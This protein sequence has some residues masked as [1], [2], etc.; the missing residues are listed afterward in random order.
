MGSKERKGGTKHLSMEG[1]EAADLIF[2]RKNHRSVT[3]SSLNVEGISHETAKTD[4]VLYMRRS[5]DARTMQK[6]NNNSELVSKLLAT[7]LT[8]KR[9]NYGKK[10]LLV[11]CG[12]PARG[13]S[14]IS[15]KLHRYLSWMGYSCKVFNVGNLRR[16]KKNENQEHDSEFFDPKNQ[17]NCDLRNRLAMDAL[18]EALFWLMYN[19]G[20]LAIH[21]ATNSNKAR[22]ASILHRCSKE[23]DLEVIFVESICTDA[24]VLESNIRLK[25]KSPDYRDKDPEKALADFRK[26]L[27]NYETSYETIEDE[28]SDN[29]IAYIKLIDVGSKV[30][31]RNISGYL[32]GQVVSYLMNMHLKQR[33]IYLTRHGESMYNLE[34]RLGGNSGLSKRG[35]LYAQAFS[36]FIQTREHMRVSENE[37]VCVFTS[38][39]TR[40]VE[41]AK[42]LPAS[43]NFF[44]TPLLNEL[45][46]G[47]CEHL[48]YKEV[49]EQLPE[50]FEARK[51]DKLRYRYPEG[52]ESYLDVVDRV[53]PTIVEM[54]RIQSP[55]II[56]GHLAV[57]RVIYAYFMDVPLENMPHMDFPLHSVFCLQQKPYGMEEECFNLDKGYEERTYLYDCEVI[58]TSS[59]TGVDPSLV[60]TPSDQSLRSENSSKSDNSGGSNA[61]AKCLT[62]E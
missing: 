50:E 35:S 36:K 18:E 22:R 55:I 11:M 31:S 61:P 12:L 27:A 52:G 2:H 28:E 40:T 33:P 30:I 38:C 6:V 46:S 16:Q 14:F 13:K 45:F 24:N 4:E 43:Y 37:G 59:K 1:D 42:H 49:L 7:G 56:I 53:R 39:L 58:E 17:S 9:N 47:P 20:K 54:E 5:F 8:E 57:L 26:R 23:K 48:T 21:D 3:L 10:V 19:G 32:P 34:G 51:A 60:R 29:G 41:T 25:L 15:N 62:K 44:K